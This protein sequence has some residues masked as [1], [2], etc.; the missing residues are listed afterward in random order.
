[1]EKTNQE[2]AAMEEKD[3][4][5]AVSGGAGYKR[6]GQKYKSL[7]VWQVLLK[8]TDEEHPLSVDDIQ[9]HLRMYGVETERRSIYRDIKDLKALLE[10]DYNADIEDRERLGYEIGYTRKQPSGFMVTQRPYSFDDV[11]LLAECINSAKFISEGQAENL[12]EMLGS[13]CSEKQ[14][15]RLLDEVY[16]IDRV[17]TPNKEVIYT[18]STLNEAI[19]NKHKIGFNYLKYTIQDRKQQTARRKGKQYVVS[20]Y[21]L[22]INDGNYYVLS[23]DA[24][25]KTMIPY[26]VDRM[27][28]V[29]ELDEA[30]E[31]Y[32]EYQKIDVRT[33]TRRVFG[34]FGGQRE[35]VI[36]RFTNDMLD[37]VVDRFGP[38]GEDNTVYYRPE[39]KSHFVLSADIDISNQFFSWVC[40][41]HKKAVIMGPPVVV[42]QF[43]SFLSDISR[44]YNDNQPEG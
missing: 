2:G 17:K 5:Q 35:R 41:F 43:K 13:F 20:P 7:L 40:G 18:L 32:E 25:W 8:R 38:G 26:R 23:Y 11:M 30:R 3:N 44:Y 12:R 1:M 37:T 33:Y 14:E 29:E 28:N 9:D 27:S 42:E 10:T 6:K 15:E 39:G 22:L 31:G 16:N 19:K 34:M 4:A 36:I 21:T 24:R